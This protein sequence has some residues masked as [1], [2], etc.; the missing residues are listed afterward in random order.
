MIGTLIFHTLHIKKPVF[1]EVNW[2]AWCA[3]L[4]PMQKCSPYF[5]HQATLPPQVHS[6][7]WGPTHTTLFFSAWPDSLLPQAQLRNQLFFLL[8]AFSKSLLNFSCPCHH[9]DSSYFQFRTFSWSALPSTRHWLSHCPRYKEG[10]ATY[11][12]RTHNLIMVLRQSQ[13]YL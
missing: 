9:C 3:Q 2:R 12:Q 4:N 7:Y 5:P 13:K 11:S 8:Q 6:W 10:E 1:K